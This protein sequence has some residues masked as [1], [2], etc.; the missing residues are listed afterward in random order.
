[1]PA[2][3][4]LKGARQKI[5]PSGGPSGGASR[6]SRRRLDQSAALIAPVALIVG[7]AIGGGG[8]DV[9]GRHIAGLAVWLVVVGLLVFG[10]ASSATLG[11]PFFWASGLIGALALLS[12]ISAFWSGSVELSV[13]E[14]DRIL[15]Y[16]GFFLAAFLIAQTDQRRQRF[17]EGWQLPSHSLPSWASRAASFPTSWRSAMGSAAVR[18]C[19]TRSAIGMQTA[20]SA[21]SRSHC[22]F[23]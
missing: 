22:C 15:V 1:M 8:F 2:E 16:L 18:A 19:A 7:L 23:G 21:G 9:S 4:T 5:G 12:A 11:R 6:A 13:I 20:R 14:A 17:A 10:A 3:Q